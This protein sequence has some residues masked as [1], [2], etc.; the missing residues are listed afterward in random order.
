MSSIIIQPASDS[1]IKLSYGSLASVIIIAFSFSYLEN[2]PLTE[3]IVF[4]GVTTSLL[5]SF[6]YLLDLHQYLL[7]LLITFKPNIESFVIYAKSAPLLKDYNNLIS[8]TILSV[9]FIIYSIIP[10]FIP[11]ISIP[12][13][14]FIPA[15]EHVHL[16]FLITLFFIFMALLLLAKLKS[17]ITNFIPRVRRTKI[18]YE[19]YNDPAIN[20]Q[21]NYQ[22]EKLKEYGGYLAQNDWKNEYNSFLALKRFAYQKFSLNLNKLIQFGDSINR[23]QETEILY[24][25]YFDNQLL[26]AINTGIK[27]TGLRFINDGGFVILNSIDGLLLK[28]QEF[29]KLYSRILNETIKIIGYS[30]DQM[31]SKNNRNS[32]GTYIKEQI[33]N[34]SESELFISFKSIQ[35][36]FYEVITHLVNIETKERANTEKLPENEK[37]TLMSDNYYNDFNRR[38]EEY[39]SQQKKGN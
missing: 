5:G 8:Q 33:F 17:E 19:M 22:F 21:N 12:E 2:L 20:V 9:T 15:R 30:P 29:T 13:G 37:I 6:L 28:R 16:N 26:I 31:Q 35:E 11:S 39:N 18:Y 36:Y 24:K 23:F 34:N 25:V 32:V 38:I 14:I 4:L 7:E 10:F 27:D 3:K 1:N